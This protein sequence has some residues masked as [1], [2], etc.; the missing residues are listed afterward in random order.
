MWFLTAMSA[1]GAVWLWLL[2]EDPL[3]AGWRVRLVAFTCLLTLG[4]GWMSVATHQSMVAARERA[5][6]EGARRMRQQDRLIRQIREENADD[7]GGRR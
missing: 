6:A 5:L 4:F 2:P 7:F 1:V 3:P